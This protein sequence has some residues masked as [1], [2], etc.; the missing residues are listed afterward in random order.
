MLL[1]K[2]IRNSFLKKKDIFIKG[3]AINSKRVKKNYIFFAIKGSKSNGENYIEEAIK[4]GASL[5]V[6]SKKCKFKSKDVEIIKTSN[7]RSFLSKISSRFY[8]EKPKNIFAV[9]GTNGK[10]S[11]ADLFYQILHLNNTPVASIGTLGIKFK[12]KIIK[13]KLTSPDTILLHK[14][15]YELKKKRCRKCY[16]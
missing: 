10:T 6:C 8:H 9:T 11:V 4:K 16:S 2:L 3:L 15:L 7:V 14:K 13:S 1:R 12:G 5:V